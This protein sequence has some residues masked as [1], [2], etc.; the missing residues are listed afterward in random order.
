MKKIFSE[1]VRDLVMQ[2]CKK[3]SR[4]FDYVL[5]TIAAVLASYN[6]YYDGFQ[7]RKVFLQSCVL[8]WKK[9]A[10]DKRKESLISEM[11]L[12]SCTTDS[13]IFEKACY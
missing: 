3:T 12:T 6:T 4:L 9:I 7:Y 10:S 8:R 11:T 5:A 1:P 2:D 13:G